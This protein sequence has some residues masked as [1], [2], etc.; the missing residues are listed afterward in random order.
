VGD[1]PAMS[2]NR[3]PVVATI[4]IPTHNRPGLLERA[5]AS[6]LAQT[7]PDL[8]VVVVDDGSTPPVRLPSPD[9]R[10]QV[11][12]NPRPLGPSAARNLGLQAAAGPW[13]TFPDDD[14]ELLPDMVRVS[15]EAA[16]QSILPQ[17][18]AVLSGV[19]VVDAHGRSLETRL[20]TT[21]PRQPPPY[22]QAPDD[23]F[24]QDANTLFAPTEL[25]RALGGW[26]ETIKGWEMDDLLIRL[27]RHCSLQA[28]PQVTY[29]R[30]RHG[31][32]RQSAQA[33]HMLDGGRLVLR[34]HR[35]FY[36]AHPRLYGR[37]L[38][39]LGVGYLREGRWWPAARAMTT[40]LRVDPR[41]PKALLQWLGTLTGPWLYGTY[42]EARARRAQHGTVPS[43][44]LQ[45][46]EGTVARG[47]GSD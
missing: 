9:P 29:R 20:P 30:Y 10:L 27:V 45:P 46:P 40:S 43:G 39:I 33:A 26:D 25:L 47:P 8:Q 23:G 28:A 7:T 3:S 41:R 11:V 15:L 36:R 34:R 21:V 38:A 42:L 18:V 32:T 19:E 35:A 22:R 24:A 6:A 13:V 31:A 5:V 14:D 4:V 17:P 2:G 44:A 1:T 16:Q 37:Q 12:R